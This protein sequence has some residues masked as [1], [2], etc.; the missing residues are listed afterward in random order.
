VI[1]GIVTY[2]GLL[3]VA[4]NLIK[5]VVGVG[6]VRIRGGGKGAK[7]K[8]ALVGMKRVLR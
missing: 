7:G 3:E 4:F 6:T 5:E 2:I 1:E 8:R